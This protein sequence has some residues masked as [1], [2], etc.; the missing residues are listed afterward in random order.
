[1]A[2]FDGLRF[3][4]TLVAALG[5]GLMA[6]VFFAFS[7][8]VI[9]ALSRL[10]P[11]EGIDAMRSINV[12]IINPVFLGVFVG[13]AAACVFVMIASILQWQDPGA[14]YLV[15]GG[16][17]YLVGTFFVTLVFNVPKNNALASVAPADP[18]SARIW[19]DYVSTWTAWN[20]VGAAAA[21]AASALLTVALGY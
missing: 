10:S 19:T 7:V 12:A 1:M 17:L 11:A 2:I 21:F 4:L 14:V 6:G 3:A 13:T 20:H 8:S 9:K 16:A 18:T 5:C 15:F